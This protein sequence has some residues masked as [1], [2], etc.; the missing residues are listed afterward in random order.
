MKMVNFPE[1]RILIR[2]NI[3]LCFFQLILTCKMKINIATS[4]SKEV[5]FGGNLFDLEVV[6]GSPKYCFF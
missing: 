3:H 2:I 4:I 6:F 1:H 5:I